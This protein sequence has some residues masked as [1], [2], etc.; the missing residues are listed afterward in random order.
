MKHISAADP[1]H[2]AFAGSAELLFD[3]ADTID[4]ITSNPPEWYA[5]GENRLAVMGRG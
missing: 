3:V 2:I 1:E 5:S 4:G